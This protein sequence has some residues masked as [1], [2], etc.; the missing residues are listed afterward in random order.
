MEI[1]QLLP[2]IFSLSSLAA[3]PT[4]IVAI[5]ILGEA[6]GEGKIGMRAIAEVIQ[7]RSKERHLA[8]E[9]VCLQPKQFSCNNKQI[10]TKLL[11]SPQAP[12]AL[13][14][15]KNINTVGNSLTFG[16][17]HYCVTN[18]APYWAK[19]LTPVTV[20]GRHKFFKVK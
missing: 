17:N 5:T 7:Q 2:L 13:E 8:P 9:V 1:K 10:N 18:I 19:G 15:A 4:E 16:A 6:R 11:Q 20:I 12:I 3:S 14:L